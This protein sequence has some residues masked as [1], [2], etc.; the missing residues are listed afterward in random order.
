VAKANV[1]FS[2]VQEGLRE[3]A[4]PTPRR[5]DAERWLWCSALVD[6][7]GLPLA[8]EAYRR[9]ALRESLPPLD[10]CF[11]RPDGKHPE[12]APLVESG[13]TG[14]E[15]RACDPGALAF[16]MVELARRPE[17]ARM[18]GDA[19]REAARNYRAATIFG[20]VADQ[21]L[22]LANPR[23]ARDGLRDSSKLPPPADL[24]DPCPS[25]M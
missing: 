1:E 15:Y 17:H 6:W 10:V 5:T 25:V 11:A 7:K 23:G 22:R 24:E 16:H 19:A 8:F 21:L 12:S 14:L 9:A 13:R 2:R 18:L 4:W 3:R 20:P